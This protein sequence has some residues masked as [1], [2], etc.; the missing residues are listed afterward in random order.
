VIG[1][2]VG[3]IVGSRFEYNNCRSKN[4]E[5]FAHGCSI[6]DDSI[7]SLAVAKAIIETEKVKEPSITKYDYDPDYYSLLRKLTVKF[8]QQIGRKYPHCGYGGMFAEWV[9][10][11][12]PR[13]YNSFGNGAAMRISPAGYA[14]RTEREAR[15]LAKTITEVTHNHA[16]GIK[17]AEA[18]AMA[19]FLARRGYTKQEIR[20]IIGRDYYL[21]DFRI[22][23]IRETYRFNETCQET[24][25]QAIE[26]FL[27]SASFEDAIRTAISLGGD[28]DTIAAI[29]GGI[30]EAYYGVPT[31]I[32]EKALTYLDEELRA[33][34]DEWIKIIGDDASHDRFRVLTKYIG[35]ISIA[36]SFGECI[37]YK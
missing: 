29:T 28:S 34:Y 22:D 15:Q 18:T 12:D 19:V 21:L 11:N 7:M 37:I 13:P 5:L 27:E 32:Q 25:P 33:I 16:E 24:V 4:F 26:A 10:S 1:A 31:D 35:K 20:E 9:F 23:D 3:D 14:A 36:D 8:M 30:A 6:T 2:I 17:G